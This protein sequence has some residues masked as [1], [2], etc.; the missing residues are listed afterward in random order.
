MSA[1]ANYEV[2]EMHPQNITPMQLGKHHITIVEESGEVSVQ[3]YNI[4]NG[5]ESTHFGNAHGW[6]TSADA[7]AWV[8][9][10]FT[11]RVVPTVENVSKPQSYAD[12]QFAKMMASFDK[13][14]DRIASINN[15]LR[16]AQGGAQ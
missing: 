12:E 3:V 15:A 5:D 7:Q 1:I 11:D 10:V 6:K 9:S 16:K 2:I 14:L 8:N 4:E 13:T